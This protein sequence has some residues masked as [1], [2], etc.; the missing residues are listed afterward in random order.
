M[1][2]ICDT[3]VFNFVKH[4]NNPSNIG[5]NHVYKIKALITHVWNDSITSY[6]MS[7]KLV[8]TDMISINQLEITFTDLKLMFYLL[9][10]T[11]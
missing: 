4:D 10:L 5:Q 2:I 9:L 1:I 6:D 7:Q 8:L 11:M 3:A